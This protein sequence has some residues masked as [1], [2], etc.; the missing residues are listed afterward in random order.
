MDSN[1]MQPSST[2]GPSVFPN[3]QMTKNDIFNK[4]VPLQILIGKINLWVS[5]KGTLHGVKELHEKG[6]YIMV[7]T[8]CNKKI[9]GKNSKNSKRARW[10]RNRWF[11]DPC[12]K[13]KIPGWKLKRFRGKK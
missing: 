3:D 1:S 8:H 7:T 13:C 11:I 10:L 5:K 6:S 4:R 9:L 12:K 2:L